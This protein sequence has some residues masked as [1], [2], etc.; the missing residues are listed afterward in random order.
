MFIHWQYFGRNSLVFSPFSFE[1]D[2]WSIFLKVWVPMKGN[3]LHLHAKTAVWWTNGQ[4]KPI[5]W[6]H[7]DSMITAGCQT[8]SLAVK[9]KNKFL[10]DGPYV[11]RTF[12]KLCWQI[13]SWNWSVN[14]F[15]LQNEKWNSFHDW[16][17]DN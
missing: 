5:T 15:D 2:V 17:N 12:S 16:N 10:Q 6:P 3:S 4:W 14:H 13:G 7:W 11:F 9:E 1:P 8:D